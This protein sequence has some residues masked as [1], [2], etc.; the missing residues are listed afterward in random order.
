M[1]PPVPKDVLKEPLVR[2]SNVSVPIVVAYRNTAAEGVCIPGAPYVT[3]MLSACDGRLA[4]DTMSMASQTDCK[5][6]NTA[7]Q[8]APFGTS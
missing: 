5:R 4:A 6:I 7:P 2:P 1:A 8:D 3:V